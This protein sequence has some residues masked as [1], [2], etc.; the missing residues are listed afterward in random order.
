MIIS[1]KGKKHIDGHKELT[2]HQEI[3]DLKNDILNQK[4]S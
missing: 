3:V 1:S 4:E 2:A